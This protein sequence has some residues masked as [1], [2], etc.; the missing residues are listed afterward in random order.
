M[1][2]YGNLGKERYECNRVI[3]GTTEARNESHPFV[4]AHRRNGEKEWNEKNQR[5]VSLNVN[6]YSF[7]DLFFL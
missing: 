5:E 4:T 7:F 2:V 6:Q 1:Q 3:R